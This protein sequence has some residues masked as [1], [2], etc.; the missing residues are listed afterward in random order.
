[1]LKRY[2]V[3]LFITTVFFGCKPEEQVPI[4]SEPVF[5]TNGTIEGLPFNLIAGADSYYMYTTYDIDT[6]GVFSFIGSFKTVECDTTC[7]NSLSISFRNHEVNPN[8]S[9]AFNQSLSLSTYGVFSTPAGSPTSIE[10]TFTPL[11]FGGQP[12]DFLWD[13]GDGQTSTD[14]NPQHIYTVPGIYEACL[15]A[16]YINGCSSTI[17]N[18]INNGVSIL[19][20]DALFELNSISGNTVELAASPVGNGPFTYAWDFGDG[21]STNTQNVS[22]TYSSPGVYEVC[23]TTTSADGCTNT[24]CMNIATDNAGICSIRYLTDT[25]VLSNPFNLATIAIEWTDENGNV[26]TSENNSQPSSSYFKVLS[27]EDYSD[28]ELGYKTKKLDI[29]FA[30]TLYHE[31][32][33]KTINATATMAIAYP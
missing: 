10:V 30:C 11:T 2:L 32:Q 7:K 21:A 23:L 14:A 13:F 8:P 31:G 18:P 3:L 28:N 29:E 27:V 1:M 16:N 24:R 25:T 20:C 4:E 22:H 19:A 5:Y 9:T 12:S 26:F 15:T 17:C 33:S 6:I